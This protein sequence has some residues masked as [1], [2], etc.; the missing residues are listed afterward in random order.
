MSIA[1]VHVLRTGVKL[2]VDRGCDTDAIPI[3][4]AIWRIYRDAYSDVVV[5]KL[6]KVLCSQ[7]EIGLDTDDECCCTYR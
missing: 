3:T 7:C 2:G 5:M 4:S 1:T 6:I